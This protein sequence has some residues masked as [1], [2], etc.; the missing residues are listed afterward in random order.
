[1]TF[2]RSNP[3]LKEVITKKITHNTT[4]LKNSKFLIVF[5]KT[6]V[7]FKSL[8]FILIVCVFLCVKLKSLIKGGILIGGV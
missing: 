1:M 5:N 8:A 7:V 6:G 3:I 4:Y 2:L